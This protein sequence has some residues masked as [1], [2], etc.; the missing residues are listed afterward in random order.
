MKTKCNSL[1]NYRYVSIKNTYAIILLNMYE[2]S[3]HYV[4]IYKKI[5]KKNGIPEKS[6]DGLLSLFGL[7]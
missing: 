3:F 2:N 7:Q 6:Y 4:Q 1:F 5:P